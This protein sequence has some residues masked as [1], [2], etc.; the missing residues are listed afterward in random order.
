MQGEIIGDWVQDSGVKGK[1]RRRDALQRLSASMYIIF[2]RG[3]SE[4]A[5]PLFP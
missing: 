5:R 1:I 2:D 3:T 4:V